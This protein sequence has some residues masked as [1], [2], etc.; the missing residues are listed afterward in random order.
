ML[1]R[2]LIRPSQIALGELGIHNGWVKTVVG[3]LLQCGFVVIRPACEIVRYRRILA[4]AIEQGLRDRTVG[5]TFGMVWLAIYPLLFLA[6]Y[7]AV[8][9]HVL[10]VRVPNLQTGEYILA[11]FCGLVPFLAFTEGFS[12][13]TTSITSNASLVRNT[14]FP[15]ELIPLREV[16]VG[17]VSMG[18]GIAMVWIAAIAQSGPHWSH[19]LVPVIF[20]FQIML[21]AGLAWIAATLNVFFRDIGKLVPILMLFLMLVSPIGYTSDMVPEGLRQWLWI[22]PLAHLIDLY[23]TVLLDGQVPVEELGK[24]AVFAVLAMLA[25]Y[26]FLIRLKSM[27]SDH[28]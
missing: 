9:I 20:L 23:R 2:L 5:S 17:H 18:L 7:S 22:N 12:A 16:V 6:M 21:T 3:R 13:A 27:F 28:V 1:S 10:Q 11:I 8:F 4:A 15:I 25:G 26:F 24:I 19:L 14:L